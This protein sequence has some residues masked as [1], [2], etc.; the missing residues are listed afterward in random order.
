MKHAFLS[1]HEQVILQEPL[2]DTSHMLNML[3]P[4]LGKNEDIIQVNKDTG[5]EQVPEDVID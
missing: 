1:F 4:G 3:L 2:E 5:I